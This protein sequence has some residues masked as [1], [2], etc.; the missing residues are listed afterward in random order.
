M[1]LRQTRWILIAALAWTGAAA[2]GAEPAAPAPR[3]VPPLVEKYTQLRARIDELV[4]AGNMAE[5]DALTRTIHAEW[6]QLSPS[7]YGHLIDHVCARVGSLM[8]R[9][10]ELQSAWP[11]WVAR[12]SLLA[13]K[14]PV[15]LPITIRANPAERVVDGLLAAHQATDDWS[16]QRSS[17][18]LVYF[19]T[20]KSI[21]DAVDYDFDY[22]RD[23]P[24][25]VPPPKGV[26]WATG[27]SPSRIEDPKVRAEYEAALAKNAQRVRRTVEQMNATRVQAT[28]A[29]RAERLVVEVYSAPPGNMAELER[30]LETYVWNAQTKQPATKPSGDSAVAWPAP[31]QLQ[32]VTDRIIKQVEQ[33]LAAIKPPDPATQGLT[34]E[35]L[36]R[37]RRS[38]EPP[39]PSP[40]DAPRGTTEP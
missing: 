28:F 35:E 20:W 13:L 36:L 11:N 19:Q 23:G 2:R 5:V 16:K 12:Q 14:A 31:P 29:K 18:M 24:R 4:E 30:Y 8:S 22:N 27:F 39:P 17:D 33:N 37:R 32:E 10:R 25:R 21:N 9:S 6:P 38:L 26:P 34:L 15:L 1:W 40:A 7:L 3:S